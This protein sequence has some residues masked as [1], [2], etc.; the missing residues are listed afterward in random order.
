M[1]FSGLS[2]GNVNNTVTYNHGS[3]WTAFSGKQTIKNN[4]E[5]LSLEGADHAFNSYYV[6]GQRK[7]WMGYGE[8]NDTRFR[9]HTDTP[10][11]FYHYLETSGINV[12][13]GQFEG[14]GSI[15]YMNGQK[16][17]GFYF[18]EDYWR[19]VSFARIGHG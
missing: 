18:Y 10:V 1:P 15:R 19:Y 3:G 11:W 8:R 13:N 14:A 4:G 16:G 7:A 6:N 5:M 2:I 17:W 9:V 12:G